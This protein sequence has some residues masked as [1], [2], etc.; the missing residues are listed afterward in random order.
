MCLKHT[1]PALK[2]SLL[3]NLLFYLV[4]VSLLISEILRFTGYLIVPDRVT[5]EPATLWLQFQTAAGTVTSLYKGLWC[6]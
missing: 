1:H 4:F 5:G 2:V 6:R 3:S